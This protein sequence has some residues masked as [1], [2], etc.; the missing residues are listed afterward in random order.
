MIKK[1]LSQY[2]LWRIDLGLIVLPV[3]VLTGDFGTGC[4]KDSSRICSSE[5]LLMVFSSGKLSGSVNQFIGG[6]LTLK[7]FKMIHM[8][9][10][11]FIFRV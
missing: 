8:D 4:T 7:R 10:Y 9:S 3:L 6:C 5:G 1:Y 11:W 2:I